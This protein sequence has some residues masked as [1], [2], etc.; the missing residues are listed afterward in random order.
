MKSEP[1]KE[2]GDRRE[3]VT[4]AEK[5]Q[6]GRLSGLEISV[7]LE[8]G[9]V[10]LKGNNKKLTTGQKHTFQNTKNKQLKEK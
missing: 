6:R 10:L 3:E 2:S 8:E 7:R 4:G 9:K 5:V 1:R